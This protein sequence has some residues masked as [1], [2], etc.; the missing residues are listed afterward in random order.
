MYKYVSSK[1]YKQ[2]ATMNHYE[3]DRYQLDHYELSDYLTNAR[4][5]VCAWAVAVVTLTLVFAGL[6]LI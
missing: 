5:V 3:F 6:S 1:H 2:E 4:D